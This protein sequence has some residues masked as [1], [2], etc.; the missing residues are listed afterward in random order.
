MK[1]PM[2]KSSSRNDPVI[3]R[4]ADIKK[5][6]SYVIYGRAGTGKTTLASTFPGPILLLDVRDEGTDSIADVEDVDVTEIETWED[7]EDTYWYL[8]ENPGL[9]KTV[10]VDTITNL[11]QIAVEDVAAR[12]KKDKRKAGDWGTMTKQDWGNVAQ[13]MK[14]WLVDYRD[15]PMETV[16]LAQDRIFNWDEDGD[17]EVQLAPEVGPRLMPSVSSAINAAVGVIGCTFIRLKRYH[18]KKEGQKKPIEKEKIQYCLRIGPNP[19]YITKIRKPRK[20]DLP[21]VIVDPHYEDIIEAI[22]GVI[23]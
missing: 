22:E 3:K 8:K 16:F 21:D 18:V 9:Y 23:K 11:Q 17:E 20:A 6:R 14:S 2:K 12:K 1:R 4:V 13:R 19:V 7:F 10:V 5:S 15:L